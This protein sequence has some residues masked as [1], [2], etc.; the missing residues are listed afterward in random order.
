MDSTLAFNPADL[1]EEPVFEILTTQGSIIIQ[2]YKDTPLHRDNF[3]KLASERY[4]DSL[5]FHRVIYNFMI[6]T[7]DPY[8]KDP[9][10]SSL[11]GTGGPGYTI[12]AE[13][14]PNHTHKKGALA[15]ARQS[16]LVNPDKESSGSQ[17]YIVHNEEACAQLDG[18]YTVFGETLEGLDVIDR[19]ASVRTDN[20]S[21]PLND[22]RILKIM[23][24][25]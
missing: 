12:P 22:I 15:A 18:E 3:V 19:I 23:P 8:T 5:L 14:L 6:Q 16:D 10:K 4:Y 13:I 11:Y 9:D 1:P 7:G 20:M 24:V 25:I 21:R 17:F 2:L